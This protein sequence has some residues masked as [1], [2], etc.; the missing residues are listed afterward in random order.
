MEV[1]LAAPLRAR[2]RKKTKAGRYTSDITL[3]ELSQY[4]H[5][6]TE[7]ACQ[8]L[9][10]GLTILKRLCRKFGLARW[11]YRK[12]SKAAR[13]AGDVLP[14]S[15]AA[16]ASAGMPLSAS[17]TSLHA[18]A[19]AAT[20][21]ASGRGAATATAT[22]NGTSLQAA[23]TAAAA[24]GSSGRTSSTSGGAVSLGRCA[25]PSWAASPLAQS[26]PAAPAPQ[27]HARQLQSQL[28]Q[29]QQEQQLGADQ[30]PESDPLPF[31]PSKLDMLMYAI[32]AEAEVEGLS[33]A[34]AGGSPVSVTA[35]PPHAAGSLRPGSEPPA[36][37][38]GDF[39][40]WAHTVA[41]AGVNGSNDSSAHYWPPAGAAAAGGLRPAAVAAHAGL[42]AVLPGRGSGADAAQLAEMLV[43]R[44]QVARHLLKALADTLTQDGAPLG[45]AAPSLGAALDSATLS[46]S[47]T[48][49]HHGSSA[50]R[51][52]GPPPQPQAPQFQ[53]PA[54]R[55]NRPLEAAP[56]A[57]A[58]E[59]PAKLAHLL[60]GAAALSAAPAL[61]AALGTARLANLASVIQSS[62]L[63]EGQKQHLQQ[64]LMQRVQLLL[65][66]RQ[67][68][69]QSS[70][71]AAPQQW[72]A[73]QL[74]PP[75]AA[76]RASPFQ[77]LSTGA[78]PLAPAPG[79]PAAPARPAAP[80]A[81]E[82]FGPGDMV[83]LAEV[84]RLLSQYQARA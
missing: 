30:E 31:S 76:A 27:Q 13:L 15:P 65:A 6:S 35:F 72:P 48:F 82:P 41:G 58:L 25:S 70:V 28:A 3:E 46:L 11:P 67:Q 79:A 54:P 14:P 75:P 16:T 4:F 47:G 49:V 50:F 23:A 45:A 73:A 26:L 63:S 80:A 7:K 57:A 83:Q 19:A 77:A 33:P 5:M 2:S 51:R 55:P 59:R 8:H 9:G 34:D 62:N 74:A 66:Q 52:V 39:P 61:G 60:G 12:L 71:A 40:A 38:G 43:G 64:R 10:V 68:Q 22:S 42:A 84:K 17:G 18:G 69:L 56:D 53:A 78:A 32:E 37:A 21:L 1:G 81:P 20:G 36:Q 44:P 24:P 29:Q